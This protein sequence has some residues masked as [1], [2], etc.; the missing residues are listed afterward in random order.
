VSSVAITHFSIGARIVDYA[1][2]VVM[3]LA[4]IFIPMASQSDASGDTERLRKIL[5]G[6]NRACAF[7]ILPI[8]AI[9]IILGKS[10]IEVWVGAR[11]IAD[12]YPV[13]VI[14]TIPFTLMLAQATS[15]RILFGIGKHK[16]LAMVTLAEGLANV[17][18]SIL[19][20]R[21]YG[22]VGDALGTA[23][24]LTCTFVIFMPVHVCRRLGVPVMTFLRHAYSLPLL[25]SVPTVVTL[26]LL[27]RWFVAHHLIQLA[28]QL[29][30]V[31]AIYGLCFLWVLRR[32]GALRIG[33][34]V[35]EEAVTPVQ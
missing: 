33:K 21:P 20:V 5:I 6:G 10:I 4:Q 31:G 16:K 15:G 14:L 11:Y 8:A 9:L 13:L 12:S 25:L 18:L 26:L 35:P 2:E 17:I 22:I 27:R 1:S 28:A 23:I 7:I 34:I 32:N 3:G 30:I 29:L 19:L 24:P